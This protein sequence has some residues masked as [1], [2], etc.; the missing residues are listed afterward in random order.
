M[1]NFL[2]LVAIMLMAT[3]THAQKNKKP[4]FLVIWGDD[5]GW[6]NISK[7]NHGM[8]GYKT[9]NIDRLAEEGAMFTD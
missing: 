7:Y 5:I 3:F 2:I 4:N 6:A 8:M 1:K 9:P